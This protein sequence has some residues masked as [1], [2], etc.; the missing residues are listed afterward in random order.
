MLIQPTLRPYTLHFNRPLEKGHQL[1]I[2]IRYPQRDI[3]WSYWHEE[4]KNIKKGTREIKLA[5]PIGRGNMYVDFCLVN[6]NELVDWY[7]EPLSIHIWPTFQQVA[8]DKYVLE[9]Y[10]SLEVTLNGMASLANSVPVE[11]NTIP[12]PVNC[13]S[14]ATIVVPPINSRIAP[15]AWF[16]LPLRVCVARLINCNLPP[17]ISSD[18]VLV[19]LKLPLV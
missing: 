15:S 1:K 10:D 9:P 11:S 18:P 5:L 2:Q 6:N 3:E 16:I 14:L 7:T 8:L 17:S 4:K 19:K 12:S 13:A